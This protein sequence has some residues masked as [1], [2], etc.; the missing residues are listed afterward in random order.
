MKKFL[1]LIFLLFALP[2]QAQAEV[3]IRLIPAT[4]IVKSAGSFVIDTGKKVC[5][6]VTTTAFGIGEVITAP[7]RAE[8]YKPKKK[9]SYFKRP[10]LEIIYDSG[11]LYRK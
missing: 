6:G 5:E 9:L 4:E 8:T 11:K 2:S 3:Q 1:P 10:R 7:F